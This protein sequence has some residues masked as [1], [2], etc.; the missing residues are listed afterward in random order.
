MLI[1]CNRNDFLALA[2]ATAIY[3]GLIILMRR[4]SRQAEV[5]QVLALLKKAGEQGVANNI[6][7]GCCFPSLPEGAP[8]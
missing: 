7:Y 6:N 3:P 1:T 2:K 8:P 5:S 4:R